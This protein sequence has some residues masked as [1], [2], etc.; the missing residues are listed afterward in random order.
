MALEY[1]SLALDQKQA[2]EALATD[3]GQLIGYASVFNGVDAYN[4]TILPG[5]YAD[6]IPGFIER[7]TLH[8]EHDSRIRLGTIGAAR[9]DDH[10]LLVVADFHSTAEAQSAR[11]Q[12]LERM[13]RGK[14]VGL[15]IGYVPEDFEMRSDGV[16]V[17]KKIRLYE[18]SEV[19]VPADEQ[20]GVIAAKSAESAVI[21][22]VKRLPEPEPTPAEPAVPPLSFD[23]DDVRRCLAALGVMETL[24]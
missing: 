7:G 17:L 21:T 2:L 23:L 10:G 22:A 12:I 24:P 13:E 8:A 11:T 5:A 15:S 16:R 3:P 14:F 1:K 18:I 19:S 20:A 9:E 4:D 6:T